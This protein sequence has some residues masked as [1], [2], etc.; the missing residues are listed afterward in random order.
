MQRTNEEESRSV[1]TPGAPGDTVLLRATP[2]AVA[3]YAFYFLAGLVPLSFEP[4]KV[5]AKCLHGQ[6]YNVTVVKRSGSA[7]AS[8]EAERPNVEAETAYGEW[9]LKQ[10]TF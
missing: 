1:F 5:P 6:N 9:D 2:A 3:G 10:Q 8:V 7:A 4:R